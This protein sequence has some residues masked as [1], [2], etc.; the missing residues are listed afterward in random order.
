LANWLKYWPIHQISSKL[1]KLHPRVKRRQSNLY[2]WKRN[3]CFSTAVP[4]DTG[5]LCTP[6]NFAQKLC[7]SELLGLFKFK[8]IRKKIVFGTIWLSL[9]PFLTFPQIW[10]SNV[11][12]EAHKQNF[13]LVDET[14]IF[15]GHL[16]VIWGSF[17][18]LLCSSRWSDQKCC[19][20]ECVAL[21]TSFQ[22]RP[23]WSLETHFLAKY[24]FI[25][26]RLKSCIFYVTLQT[27]NDFSREN[28][29]HGG[30]EHGIRRGGSGVS[31]HLRRCPQGIASVLC[32]ETPI[33]GSRRSKLDN[34]TVHSSG[35]PDPL[36][37][38][39]PPKLGVFHVSVSTSSKLNAE[40]R[41][42]VLYLR[43]KQWESRTASRRK[44]PWLQ[45]RKNPPSVRVP[46]RRGRR[47]GSRLRWRLRTRTGRRLRSDLTSPA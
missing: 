16:N 47:A 14:L 37:Q 42:G 38:K 22:T 35:A 36:A 6:Q 9:R 19:K 34:L 32:K 11:S 39:R 23:R 20:T 31:F 7:G 45:L 43:C 5:L 1:E 10:R 24:R 30:H 12:R 26:W 2:E 15:Q 33:F 40:Y 21:K 17:V 4:S 8:I 25:K 28:H 44:T 46:G 13:E 41:T 27:Y 18:A 29:G 3:L